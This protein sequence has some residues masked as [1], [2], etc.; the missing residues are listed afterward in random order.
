MVEK[1]RR[2]GERDGTRRRREGGKEAVAEEG[3]SIEYW[4]QRQ[5]F[6]ESLVS[7]RMI[8]PFFLP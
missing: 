7:L 6:F 1:G 5:F 8:Y 2:R 4:I 3:T